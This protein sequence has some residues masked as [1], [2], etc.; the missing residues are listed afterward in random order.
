MSGAPP[1]LGAP[2]ARAG[3]FRQLPPQLF[4][5]VFGLI[6]LGL[7]W[8][9]A[10]AFG[11]PAGIGEAILGAAT[12]LWLFL[13]VAYLAKAARRPGVV[14]EDLRAL[15]GRGGLTAASLCVLLLAAAAL[16][17][18]AGLARGL[19]FG[20]LALHAGLALLYVAALRRAPPEGRRVTPI[21]HLAFVGFILAPLAAVPLGHTGLA[22]WVLAG[23][24]PVAIAIWA[25]SLRQI[26]RDGVPAPLRPLLAIHLAP[27]ALFATV[28]ASLGHAALAQGFV[29]VVLALL[30]ALAVRARWIAAAGFSPFWGAFSFPLPAAAAALLAQGPGAAGTAGLVLLAAVTP[31]VVVILWRILR[32]WPGGALAARTNA[33]AA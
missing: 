25:L 22:T 3:P 12:A 24:L 9:R 7:A 16:P 31:A 8:R 26:A 19:L 21:W 33:A 11:A 28:A 20:G 6:G 2:A 13:A 27:A 18:S 15:P 1:P 17:Y 23:T 32:L 5:P 30:A 4:T 14:G 29:L 10:A